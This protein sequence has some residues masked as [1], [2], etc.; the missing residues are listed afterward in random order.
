LRGFIAKK[1]YK[2]QFMKK[3][4]ASAGLAALGV[5]SLQAAYAPGLT[6]M[7]KSKPWSISAA[8]RGFYDDNYNTAPDNFSRDSFGFELSPSVSLNLPMDQ[9][10]VGA[11]YLYSMR[12]YEN[13]KNNSADHS[14][15]FKGKLTHAFSERYRIAVN[16]SFVIA[17]EPEL[18]D[19]SISVPLR[20]EG[21]NM[22][23]TGSIDFD[24]QLTQLLGLSVGYRNSFFDYEQEG[25]NS[26]SALLDR[27]ENRANL[28][29]RWQAAPKTVA[30][31]GY[32]FEDV[33]YISDDPILVGFFGPFGIPGSPT[34]RNKRSHS[35]YVGADQ[36]F[37]SQLNAS[38]RVGGTYTDFYNQNRDTANPYADANLTY[39]YLP[40]SYL[41]V[42]VRH[43]RNATDVSFLGTGGGLTTDQESTAGYASLTHKI[44]AKLTGVLLGQVVHSTFE[45]G[46][47]DGQSENY[48][49]LGASLQYQI[50]QYF[51]A[52]TGYNYDKLDT[53]LPGREFDRNRVYI[54]VRATY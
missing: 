11:S 51:L 9:T 5:A 44:T 33:D 47:A 49:T 27:V 32:R 4:I 24:A 38:I 20:A 31:L 45:G 22:R 15:E 42:G 53:D 28:D 36:N 12:Y 2:K 52:E 43:D 29:F 10:F 23:N 46:S 39:A 16:D 40:G 25:F 26:Y 6:S 48:Y 14:H 19:P 41:Q 21:N 34:L 1:G 50:N 54:G 30:V 7:E 8:L 37:N 3:I 35:I 13:R 18:I 17:Q